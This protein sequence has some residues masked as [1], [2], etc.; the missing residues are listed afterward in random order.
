M[1]VLCVHVEE[2]L[3]E[4]NHQFP[5]HEEEFPCKPNSTLLSDMKRRMPYTNFL[6]RTNPSF[7]NSNHAKNT[8]VEDD[9]VLGAQHRYFKNRLLDL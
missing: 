8:T 6:S 9:H 7:S 5:I 4:G 3:S 1:D 2:K